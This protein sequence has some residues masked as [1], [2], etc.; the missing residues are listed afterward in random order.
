MLTR[1]SITRATA[2]GPLMAFAPG[3]SSG[4]AMSFSGGAPTGM[5]NPE[6]S[7]QQQRNR[8]NVMIAGGALVL[9]AA[10]FYFL[11]KG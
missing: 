2:T 1:S 5:V 3:V 9:L 11:K 4:G 7:E 6:L 8:R 10:G